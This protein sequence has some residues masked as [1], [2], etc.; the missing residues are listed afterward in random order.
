MLCTKLFEIA[1]NFSTSKTSNVNAGVRA[2]AISFFH[3]AHILAE[4]FNTS[5][6]NVAG[7]LF[8][9]RGSSEADQYNCAKSDDGFFHVYLCLLLTIGASV[10][11]NKVTLP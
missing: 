8:F 10:L 1:G 9:A 11:S 3:F 7:A 4:N 2:F 6:L 5:N